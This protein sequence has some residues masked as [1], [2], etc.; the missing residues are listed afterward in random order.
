VSA[1]QKSD[2]AGNAPAESVG[3]LAD[4]VAMVTT[5]AKMA[6][7]RDRFC[8]GSRMP[9]AISQSNHEERE[10]SPPESCSSQ[11]E[12]DTAA[13]GREGYM[14]FQRESPKI[15]KSPLGCFD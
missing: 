15:P 11:L 10:L 6:T 5:T 4:A 14:T 9:T 7:H 8:R 1:A 3:S 12:N 13:L 2:S